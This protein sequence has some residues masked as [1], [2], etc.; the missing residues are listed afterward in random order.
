MARRSPSIALDRRVSIDLQAA[1]DSGISTTDDVTNATSSGVRR[2]LQRGCLRRRR[3]RLQLGRHGR[4][5]LQRRPGH[6]L[7]DSTYELT[8]S[9]CGEGTVTATFAA[10]GAADT[11]GNTGPT[12]ATDG[13][14]VLIDRTAPTATIDL[15]P[16]SDSGASATDNLT[17]ALSLTFDVD[18]DEDVFDLA[19]SD[20]SVGGSATGCSVGA[21]IGS[22]ASY[23]VTLSGCCEGTVILTLAASGVTDTA[24]N[25]NAVTS[26]PTVT[27]DRT[28]PSVVIDLQA[29]SDSGISSTDDA[30]N[31]A[32]LVFDVTFSEDVSGVAAADFSLA[33]TAA[34]GCSVDPVTALTD[35]TYEL[36]VSGCGEG[37]VTVDLRRRRRG[38]HGRQHRSHG[39]HR[40]SR[41]AHRPHRP[42]RHD[43][44]AARLG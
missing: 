26:G 13:P 41:G 19:A 5:R 9:G 24:G 36:T 15:Q 8:V 11:A 25:A 34:S 16:G 28:G 37:T 35:S 18:F 21:P 43:R 22:G 3:R 31:A 29:A 44:P 14:E 33:G 30:T 17:K 2:H 20:F 23:D 10:D 32:T 4:Q 6:R 42:D 38:R 40:R 1:S 39:R 12:A 27:V 7:T